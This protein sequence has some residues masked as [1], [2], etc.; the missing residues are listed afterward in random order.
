MQSPGTPAGKQTPTRAIPHY[1]SEH[2]SCNGKPS[3]THTYKGKRQ[4]FQDAACLL[5]QKRTSRRQLLVKV[6]FQQQTIF[7]IPLCLTHSPRLPGS[8]PP[9][10]AAGVLRVPGLGGGKVPREGRAWLSA[11]S[12]TSPPWPLPSSSSARWERSKPMLTEAAA[13]GPGLPEQAKAAISFMGD[14]ARASSWS[15]LQAAPNPKPPGAWSLR[16]SLD[17]H[18]YD[19]IYA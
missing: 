11:R 10:P 13:S 1:G 12:D 19:L 17:K 16:S 4:C 6:L 18:H 15:L 9:Q 2:C 14:Q 3:H 8:P 5:S 7:P